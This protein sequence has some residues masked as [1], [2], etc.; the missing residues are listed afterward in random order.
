MV[1]WGMVYYC[2][3]HIIHVKNHWLNVSTSK[4]SLEFL[5]PTYPVLFHPRQDIRNAICLLGTKWR[6]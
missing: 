3:T 4:P 2:Y 1:I 6:K 5:A